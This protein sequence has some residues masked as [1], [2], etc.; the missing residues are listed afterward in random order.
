MEA[1]QLYYS[2]LCVLALGITFYFYW[3]RFPLVTAIVFAVTLIVPPMSHL[4]HI[5]WGEGYAYRLCDSDANSL[6]S[7]TSCAGVDF[8][9]V[10]LNSYEVA[11]F[12]EIV[13]LRGLSIY[14]SEQRR[15]KT[16]NYKIRTWWLYFIILQ[17]ICIALATLLTVF[18]GQ[19]LSD[20]APIYDIIALLLSLLTLYYFQAIPS[21]KRKDEEEEVPL[22][23]F[24]DIEAISDSDI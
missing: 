24:V 9:E 21:T 2:I 15:A 10:Y 1:V 5:I 12:L 17:S 16:M 18:P 19:I 11:V 22:K 7:W 14:F 4:W 8:Y 13:L 23:E 20:Y 3:K 6:F